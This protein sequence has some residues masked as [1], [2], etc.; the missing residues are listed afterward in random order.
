MRSGFLLPL[1]AA[2]AVSH[3]LDAAPYYLFFIDYK[4]TKTNLMIYLMAK[5]KRIFQWKLFDNKRKK[6]REDPREMTPRREKTPTGES[7][8][9][10]YGHKGHCMINVNIRI[11][12]LFFAFTLYIYSRVQICS[13][14]RQDLRNVHGHSVVGIFIRGSLREF[15]C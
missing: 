11:K 5:D 4:G 10:L 1:L 12:N 3:L 14:W 15:G 2:S 8:Y 6:T 7:L 13:C 9:V